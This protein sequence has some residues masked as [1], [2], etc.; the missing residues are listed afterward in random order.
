MRRDFGSLEKGPFDLLVIGGGIYGAWT[1]LDASLRGLRVALLE[2]GDWASG[3]SSSSSKLIHGGLRYLEH[4][5]VGLVRK[6]LRERSRLLAIAPHRVI[7]T[8]FVVPLLPGRSCRTLQ[9]E[10]GHPPLRSL[11]RQP[12]IPSR[13]RQLSTVRR[14]FPDTLSS[15][16]RASWVPPPTVTASPTTGGSPSKSWRPRAVPGACRRQLRRGGRN[17]LPRRPRGGCRGG[18][19]DRRE[20]PARWRRAWSSTRPAPGSESSPGTATSRAP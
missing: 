8:R 12:A 14:P 9:D 19:P 4:L 16:R 15:P 3:T 18:G 6:S 11:R 13:G 5:R 10:D 2:K 1:S 7:P 17:P 20:H